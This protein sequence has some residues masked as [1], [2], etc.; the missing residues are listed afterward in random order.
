MPRPHLRGRGL[1]HDRFLVSAE[2]SLRRTRTPPWLAAGWLNRWR[3]RSLS[4]SVTS[5]VHADP[6][7]PISGSAQRIRVSPRRRMEPRPPS[8]LLLLLLFCWPPPGPVLAQ[9]RHPVP[10][11]WMMP[12]SGG[13][14][15]ENV[16][17]AVAPAVRLA[18][19][20]LRREPPP[21]GDYELQLQLL[22]SQVGPS[23][24]P[25]PQ[26]ATSCRS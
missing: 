18:L 12:V 5:C 8:L 2:L 22:D 26:S 10:V 16:T 20:D 6:L 3:G 4:C 23:S 15:R 24:A 21:L 13:A 11:L 25:R 7:I 9:V 1:K 17:A 14:G 19:R